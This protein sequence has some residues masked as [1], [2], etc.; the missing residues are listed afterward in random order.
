MIQEKISRC[1][2][3]ELDAIRELVVKG[4]F[5]ILVGPMGAYVSWHSGA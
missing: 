2:S 1:I 5:D 3:D 4:Q